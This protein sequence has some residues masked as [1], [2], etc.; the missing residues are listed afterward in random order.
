MPGPFLSLRPVPD[1]PGAKAPGQIVTLLWR[2]AGSPK[3]VSSANPFSAVKA[4]AYYYDAVLWAVE[5][6]IT[7]GTSATTF[8]PGSTVTRGQTVTFPHRSMG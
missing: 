3:A 4:G 6:K 2:A 8:A 1:R 7:N 5:T